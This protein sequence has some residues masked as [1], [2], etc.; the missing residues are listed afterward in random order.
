GG[1]RHDHRL[2][3]RDLRVGLAGVP[4]ARRPG[5]PGEAGALLPRRRR[6]H[7]RRGGP[8]VG[9]RPQRGRVHRAVADRVARLGGM[10]LRDA[11]AAVRTGIVVMAVGGIAFLVLAVVLVPWS[12]V[13]GGTPHPVPADQVFTAE[14][15]ARAEDFSR[16]ARAWSWS[17]L[18][19]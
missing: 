13:P 4:A 8:A 9:V 3:R 7:G 6:R 19:V 18:A 15:V 17:S 14:Q 2:P 12:P 5:R 1:V 16:W 10:T 11:R